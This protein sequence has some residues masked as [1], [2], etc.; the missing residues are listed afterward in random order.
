MC[1]IAG[2]FGTAPASVFDAVFDG[3]RHRGPDGLGVFRDQRLALGMN[4]LR[5]RGADIALPVRQADAV[6]AYN[7]QVYGQHAGRRYLTA[8]EGLD[9][10]I[11]L[12]AHTPGADGMYA[13]SRYAPRQGQVTLATDWHFIK[14]LFVRQLPDEIVFASEMAALLRQGAPARLHRGALAELFAYGW[15]LSDQT[16]AAGVSLVWKDDVAIDADGLRRTPKR[17][18]RPAPPAAPDAAQLRQAIAASV[19]RSAQGSG[20]LGLALSGGLDSSILACELNAQGVENVVCVTVQTADGD[21]DLGA[22]A[23]LGLPPAGAWQTWKHVVVPVGDQDFL[24]GFAAATRAF[25][26]PTTMSSL[27]LYQRLADAAAAHGVR[28]MLLGEGVDEYFG[29]YGS[30]AKVDGHA[31]VQDY[32]RNA[33]RRRLVGDLFGDAA[34]HAVEQRFA[35]Q[36][37]ACHDLRAI[38]TQMRL[39]RLLLRSDVC[40]MSRSIEGRVPF[41][42]NHIPDL[43]LS[44]DWRTLTG[45]LGKTFLRQAYHQQLGPRALRPKVRFKSSDAMLLRCLARDEMALRIRRQCGRLF[46][47]GAV[48]QALARLHAAD[49]FDAD[50]LCL[51]MSLTFLLESEL[52]DANT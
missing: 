36:Y 21:D 19:R 41:L 25:G 47:A 34:A 17:A 42:Y 22:L 4:R 39:T 23:Q 44:L 3:I 37:G 18:Q 10:E 31:A 16:C 8:V 14:P 11:A 32:Y 7:G 13:Y 52:L 2:S 33:A 49:G 48:A 27:P 6:S 28:A 38:E 30:Y 1:G 45:G 9:S 15:Y 12:A 26:Q 29:G 24:T 20:P 51:L 40:L 35:Q 50:I 5:F 46:G 43:A